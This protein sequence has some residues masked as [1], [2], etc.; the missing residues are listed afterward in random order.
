MSDQPTPIPAPADAHNHRLVANVHPADWVNPTPASRYNLVVIGGGTAGLI[1]A[2]GA[3]GLGAKV[4]L[5]ER[6][7]LGGDCLNF[8]CVP[9][10]SLLRAARAVA[11]VRDAG[12]FGVNVPPGVT[13]NF[14]QVMERLRRVRADLSRHDS[15]AR[16][17]EL[18]VDVFLGD[19]RFV[20]GDRIAVGAHEL[21]FAKAV[22]ATGARAT[23]PA[24]PG[25]ADAGFFTNETIF[26]LTELPRRLAVIG[27]GP[28]GC[29]LAQ[30]FRRFGAEVALL[31]GGHRFLGRE[32][33]DAAAVIAAA[34]HRDG[35][36]L[37][38]HASV[39]RVAARGSE[40]VLHLE[41]QGQTTERAGDAILV[42]VGRAPNV[43]HLGLD[44]AGVAFS[45]AGVTVNDRLQTTNPRV[46]A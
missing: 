17:R 13:V 19:A 35:V 28:I 11:D 29:E 24:I 32:D 14:P 1:C 42:G 26:S 22:I 34:F 18:G 36:E 38:E 23:A 39:T 27:A 9:S 30:A 37:L 5:I 12:R 21:R 4:A 43:E 10:K 45:A 8:G 20:G 6:H 25:L 40:R 44:Q 31:H 7:L 16:F 3:A 15:A 2:A 46:F 41:T 33:R